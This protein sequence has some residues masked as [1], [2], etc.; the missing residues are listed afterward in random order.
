M[1]NPIDI[2]FLFFA[3]PGFLTLLTVRHV[4]L[5]KRTLTQTEFVFYSLACSIPSYLTAAILAEATDATSH[6]TNKSHVATFLIVIQTAFAALYGLIVGIVIRK[7]WRLGL[8]RYTPWHG[9][10]TEGKGRRV[11]VY[12]TSAKRYYGWIK[13]ASS[14]DE[15][16]R[17]VVLGDPVR[18]NRDG[19][20][21]DMGSEMLF[22]EGEIARVVRVKFNDDTAL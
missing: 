4:A 8:S 2:Y 6:L 14:D 16:Q 12:T 10:M 13:Q 11:I 20:E 3:L 17:E 18:L 9:F 1:T 21:V 19:S 22:C 5:Y 7:K 15:A